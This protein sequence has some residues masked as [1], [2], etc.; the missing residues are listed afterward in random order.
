[1]H[2]GHPR[3]NVGPRLGVQPMRETIS[4]FD[5]IDAARTLGERFAGLVCDVD[6][7]DVRVEPLHGWSLTDCVGHV[8]C[9]PSRYLDLARG[10]DEWPCYADSLSDVYAKQI[11][12]L[13][14]RDTRALAEILLDD[15]DE[16][17]SMVRHFGARVPMMRVAGRQ[18]VRA[19]TALG[20][21][22]GEMAVCGR[23][24]A[25]VLGARWEIEPEIAPMVIRGRHQLL[26][27]WAD[28]YSGDGHNATYQVRIRRTSERV[29][30]CFRDGHLDI[31]PDEAPDPDVFLSVEPVTAV[32]AAHG[33]CSVASA[34]L[35]GR[36]VSWGRK[37]WLSLGLTDRLAA[38]SLRAG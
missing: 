36:A 14:T 28:S 37:P 16:L 15:L 13:P 32:L 30:Y 35:S 20:I 8:A 11:A 22:I 25:R 38:R 7:P 10:R 6:T 23:D 4:R 9:E 29:V 1:M 3:G 24:I 34:L 5:Y 21:L 19:D 26:R 18:R 33:R 31:N 27:P 2:Y 12:N 17:L